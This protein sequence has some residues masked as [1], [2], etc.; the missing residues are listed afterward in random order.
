MLVFNKS[1]ISQK[2]NYFVVYWHSSES[3]SRVTAINIRVDECVE[4]E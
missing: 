3:T 2:A 1:K 4:N